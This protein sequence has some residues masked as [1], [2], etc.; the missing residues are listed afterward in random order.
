MMN[1]S[2][3]G[4]IWHLLDQKIGLP[5][6][7]LD[8]AQLGYV[9]LSIYN[10][11]VLP[12]GYSLANVIGRP[13]VERLR[14]WI[15]NGGTLIAIDNAAAFC[16]DSTIALSSVRPRSQV[17]PKLA[18]YEQAALDAI[19]NETPDVRK[20]H[21]WSY[22]ERPDTAARKDARPPLKPEELE[23]ADELARVFSPSGTIL[24]VE[25][26]TEEWLTFGLGN[27]I[28]AIMTSSTAL[29]SK[30]PPVRT[31]GRFAAAPA[32]RLS[33]LLWPEARLRLANTPY[34]TLE[35]SGMGQVILFA[36]QPNFRAFFRGTERLLSNAILFGP[37]L[38]TSWTPD[39]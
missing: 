36:D 25:L 9:D 13:T 16:A 17:L 6:S 29:V 37:G 4:W 14:Q 39:W 35:R 18:E 11:L 23:K 30:Y 27:K 2:S 32:L 33:G 10:V 26:D 21:I 1:F 34:C 12:D 19:A 5:V 8:I 31:I 15:R 28:P 38:G 24:R 20:L 3:V 22:P 7:L